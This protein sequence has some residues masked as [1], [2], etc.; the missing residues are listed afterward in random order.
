MS[1]SR[2]HAN[3]NPTRH[4]LLKREFFSEC[5]IDGQNRRSHKYC[6]GLTSAYLHHCCHFGI[7]FDIALCVHFLA[8]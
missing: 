5:L 3:I 7:Y 1:E 8:D 4:Y 6:D 2:F